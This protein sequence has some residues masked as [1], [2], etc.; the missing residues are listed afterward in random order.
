LLAQREIW[1]TSGVLPTVKASLLAGLQYLLAP[2]ASS[3]TSG[4]PTIEL[5]EIRKA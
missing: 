5:L 1:R 3:V 2:L 4:L